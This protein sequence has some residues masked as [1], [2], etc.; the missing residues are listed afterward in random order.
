LI[1]ISFL[2]PDIVILNFCINE[3]SIFY[4]TVHPSQHFEM[5]SENDTFN[6]RNSSLTDDDALTAN[7]A[8]KFWLYLVFLIPSLICSLFSLC[9]LL[10]HRTLRHA[11]NNHAIIIVLFIG[12]IYEVTIYPWMLHYY[13][14]RGV[15]QRTEIFCTFWTFIDW[16][17]YYT[18]T[19]LFA[20]ATIERHIL[21]FHDGWLST[22]KKRFFIHYLPLIVLTLYCLIY[23]IIVDFFPPCKN[24]FDDF[25]MLC[26]DSCLFYESYA[27]YMWDTIVHQI[28]PSLTIVISS[29]ALLVRIL[30]QKH[31]MGQSL[32]WRKHWKMT[33]QLLCISILYLIFTFP[34]T[35]MNFLYLCGLPDDVGTNFMNYA[36]LLNYCIMLLFPFACALSLPELRKKIKILLRRRQRRTVVPSTWIIRNTTFH[37]AR[38]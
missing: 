14:Y 9:Y 19:I 3:S 32:R 33:V 30:W 13:H 6:I 27:L 23:Y 22:K 7:D 16:G 2:S 36:L 35:L 34:I 28:L 21:I 29:I 4:L 25:Y 18:Q 37:G 10:L 17:L 8:I 12:L 5:S 1:K 38:I 15:W 26:V 31:H 11:L 20:W 24:Y